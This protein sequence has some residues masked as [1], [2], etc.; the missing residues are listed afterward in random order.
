MSDE[1]PAGVAGAPRQP[2]RRMTMRYLCLYKPGKDVEDRPPTEAEM[3]AMGKL[4]GEMAQA[5]VLL[6]SEG[7][8]PSS[9]GFRLEVSP[10]GKFTVTDGPFPETKELV[11]GMAI[12]QVKTRAEA[13][14]WTKRF[15]AVAGEGQSEVRQLREMPGK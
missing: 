8:E 5:G 10:S 11:C 9:K 12:I 6:A 1:K 7:C 4:I 15:L 14:E 13:I 2:D 3:A